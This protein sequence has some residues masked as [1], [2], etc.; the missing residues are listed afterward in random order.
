M[1]GSL[2]KRAVIGLGLSAALFVAACS[3]VYTNHGYV[4]NDSD[5]AQLEIGKTSRDEVASLIG[6]PASQGV[7]E[8]ADW[9]FVGSR[10]VRNGISAAT[11]IDRQVVAVSFNDANTVSN[12]ERFGLKDG[13]VIVLSRRVT[14]SGIKG[15][16]LITQLMGSFGRVS[17]SQFE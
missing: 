6:R 7:L 17:T 4:P 5:L 14:D 9:Y 3:P 11:E 12:V 8:G 10:W 2:L 16:S 1:I 13:Q 15:V